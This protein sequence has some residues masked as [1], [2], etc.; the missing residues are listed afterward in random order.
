MLQPQITAKPELLTVGFE[1][2]FIHAL[3][4]EAT[5][6]EVIGALWDK[7]I[8][9][10]DRVPNRVGEEMFGVIYGRPEAERSHPDELQYVAGVPVRPESEIPDGM[11]S[12]T[13][14]ASTFAVFTHRG[15]IN[16][17]GNKC[18]EVYRIWLPQSNYEHA[19]VADVELY[20]G[21]FNCESDDSVMEYW[22][23][24]KPKASHDLQRNAT[25]GES[26]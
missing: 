13:V 11:V 14:Q 1:A 23:S 15:P 12:H 6:F 19:G 3:S 25:S 26:R 5:N 18:H 22:I 9:H 10:I 21:R 8:G 24:V 2:A 4:P 17:I 16:T 20:D 7:L